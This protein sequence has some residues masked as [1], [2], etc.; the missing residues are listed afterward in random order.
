[1]TKQLCKY[2]LIAALFFSSVLLGAQAAPGWRVYHAE[3][4]ISLTRG[5]SRTVYNS[6]LP[7][8]P[9]TLLNSG[10]LVQTSLGKAEI[11]LEGSASS[12]G[13]YTI[14]KLSE[15]TSLLVDSLG[16]GQLSLELLYGRMRVVTGSAAPALTIRS[17]NAS[18][19]IREADAALDYVTRAGIT[20]PTLTIHCFKG[21]GELVPLVQAGVDISKLPIKAGE[22]LVLEYHVPFSYVE[23]KSLEGQAQTYWNENRFSSAPLSM[24]DVALS[25]APREPARKNDN[26]I[27]YTPPSVGTGVS[28][29]A[30]A[31]VTVTGLLMIGAGVILQGYGYFGGSEAKD[32]FVWGGYGSLGM[33]MAFL[34]TSALK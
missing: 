32:A 22:T 8:L 30:K 34:L 17:G 10:D 19:T 13:D 24:P 16:N 3:G 12:R 2:C 26:T 14:I 6:G 1:M 7:G 18:V 5:G 20:Q 31:G 33:G 15:N 23:R 29:R 4:E 27:T 25:Q 9:E 21:G 11:Q 28:R